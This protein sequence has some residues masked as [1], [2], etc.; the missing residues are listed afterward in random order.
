[1]Q[2]AHRSRFDFSGKR[3]RH[4]IVDL[5]R[6]H[7]DYRRYNE[8]D[9]FARSGIGKRIFKAR[10]RRFPA[11]RFDKRPLKQ[12]L[13]AAAGQNAEGHCTRR[14]RFLRQIMGIRQLR[15]KKIR[16]ADDNRIKKDRR[17]S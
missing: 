17:K 5:I 6:R 16:Y 12:G 4:K 15:R 10:K 11:G 1:M 9:D 8:C 7:A 2:T 14:L 13:K 3:G